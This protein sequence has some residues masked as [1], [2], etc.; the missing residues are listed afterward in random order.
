VPALNREESVSFR[1]DKDGGVFVADIG[2]GRTIH[3]TE[4]DIDKLIGAVGRRVSPAK[5]RMMRFKVRPR[6]KVDQ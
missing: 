5:A 1:P 2:N 6:A 4:R 3:L